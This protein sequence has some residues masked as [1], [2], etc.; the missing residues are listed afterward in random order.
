MP[1]FDT[2]PSSEQM[3]VSE[4]PL[5]PLF[6]AA[7]LNSPAVSTGDVAEIEVADGPVRR[8]SG[9]ELFPIQNAQG[10]V[11]NAWLSQQGGCSQNA[12]FMPNRGVSEPEDKYRSKDQT[13]NYQKS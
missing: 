10:P 1:H 2:S 13:R 7:G 4:T 11:T 12:D 6:V 8:E 3:V 9:P 5:H